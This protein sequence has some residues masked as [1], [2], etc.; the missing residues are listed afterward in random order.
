MFEDDAACQWRFDGGGKM[1][2][3][4][5]TAVLPLIALVTDDKGKQRQ[6]WQ[7]LRAIVH[8]VKLAINE[9]DTTS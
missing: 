2:D 6:L 1:I 5:A 8:G 7:E 9:M 3:L 4:D